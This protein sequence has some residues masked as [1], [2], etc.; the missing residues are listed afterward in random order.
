[1][2]Q[3]ALVPIALGC[4]LLAAGPAR[5]AELFSIVFDPA[6][7]KSVD[8]T[9]DGTVQDLSVGAVAVGNTANQLA[10]QF[11]IDVSNSNPGSLIDGSSFLTYCVELTQHLTN[12]TTVWMNYQVVSTTGQINAAKI[13]A[14]EKLYTLGMPL[15]PAS[16][17]NRS[18]AF[19]AA[20]WEV[21]YETSGTYQ[22]SGALSGTNKIAFNNSGNDTTELAW[23]Q[24]LLDNL[25]TVNN[26][27]YSLKVLA[28]PLRQD[29]LIA[30][31]VP[32][33]EAYGL[34]LAGMGVLG[35]AMGRQRA[36]TRA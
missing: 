23:A 18:A 35:V 24:G 5:S 19:Q 28:S 31:T 4:M 12:P 6:P 25:G 17:V 30:T 29:Y 14:L 36:K 10:G 33:P 26:S 34:A 15:N 2:R 27:T 32:E 8:I 11:R 16:D 7:A 9:T 1:M 13:A 22:L 21:V 3:F 20:V